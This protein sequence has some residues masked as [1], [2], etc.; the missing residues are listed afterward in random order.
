MSETGF[1]PQVIR[2][3][4]SKVWSESGVVIATERESDLSE[5]ALRELLRLGS[6]QFVVANVGTPLR[7]VTESETFAFWK[8]E[9]RPHLA[10][11]SEDGHRL[12]DFPDNYFYHATRWRW[13]EPAALVVLEM[14]H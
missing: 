6:V 11:P 3:P 10:D 14:H 2:I 8:S 4:L 9:V 13:S 5:A 12:D 7:W 1:V